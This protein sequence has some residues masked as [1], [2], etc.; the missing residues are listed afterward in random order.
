MSFKS[1]R[2]S[3]ISHFE[4]QGLSGGPMRG[5]HPH[6]FPHALAKSSTLNAQL[7]ARND[8]MSRLILP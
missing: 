2:Q 1:K 8:K 5:I 7:A 6:P 3:L 4:S